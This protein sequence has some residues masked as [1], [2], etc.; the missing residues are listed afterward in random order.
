M[1]DLLDSIL[2]NTTGV[3]AGQPGSSAPK[4]PVKGTENKKKAEDQLR[5]LKELG[6]ATKETTVTLGS[7]VNQTGVDN[8]RR[9]RAEHEEKPLVEDAMESLIST[10]E[11]ERRFNLKVRVKDL[12]LDSV[13]A[14]LKRASRLDQPGLILDVRAWKQLLA[15]LPGAPPGAGAY[16]SWINRE[17]R[18]EEFARM[19]K[20]SNGRELVL[21]GRFPDGDRNRPTC[22]A[23]VTDRYTP[24]G[25]K[26]TAQTVLDLVGSGDLDPMLRADVSYSGGAATIDLTG[27]TDV[28]PTD[29]VAGEVFRMGTRLHASDDKSSTNTGSAI[30]ERN[31]CLNLII[32]DFMSQRMFS[33]RH[34]GSREALKEALRDGAMAVQ[35]K[36]KPFM[37]S[38]NQARAEKLDALSLIAAVKRITAAEE[39]ARK[40]EAVISIP[41]VEQGLL[42]NW[43]L[44]AHRLEPEMTKVGLVNAICRTPQV[45]SWPDAIE[46][47]ELL[48]SGAGQVLG[49]DLGTLL[50]N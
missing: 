30:A 19:V 15:L 13:T 37:E 3:G 32:L 40:A 12:V 8:A 38:W 11:K 17:W 48:A 9:F 43:I 45:G 24:F 27:F 44:E 50:Q 36:I 16:T 34:V 2:S 46:A 25:V 41:G 14:R 39:G 18:A 33:V 5:S 10:V 7:A 42:L 23:A 47:E 21:R 26:E 4:E 29:F 49:M 6:F 20:Q 22:Y 35:A 28:Q 1:T 31:L